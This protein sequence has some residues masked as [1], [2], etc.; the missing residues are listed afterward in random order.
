MFT[1][2]G[3]IALKPESTGPK[4]IVDV[5]KTVAPC[6]KAETEIRDN[7]RTKNKIDDRFMVMLKVF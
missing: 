4:F 2:I 1:T 7:A 3:F 6:A 5:K